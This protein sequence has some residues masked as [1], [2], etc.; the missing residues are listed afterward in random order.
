VRKRFGYRKREAVSKEEGRPRE[1]FTT[2]HGGT[3]PL[4][5][6]KRKKK[7]EKKKARSRKGSDTPERKLEAGCVRS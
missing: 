2:G 6:M 1:N 7:G 4:M 5:V 3:A